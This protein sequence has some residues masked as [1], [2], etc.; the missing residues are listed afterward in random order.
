M[1]D[2]IPYQP[3]AAGPLETENV[4]VVVAMAGLSTHT[5]RAYKRWIRNYLSA[6]NQIPPKDIDLKSLNVDMAAQSFGPAPLKAWL[7]KLKA[8]KLGKQSIMQAKASV[9][10]LAQFMADLGRI[11]YSV[12]SGLSRVKAPRAETGQRSGTWLTQDEI[13]QLL[14]ALRRAESGNKALLTRNTAIIVLMVT[15][16]LRRDEV[17]AA[18]WSDLARQGRNNI[19]RVH[20]KGEKLRTVKVPDMAHQAIEAWRVYHPLP[21]GE[22]AVFTRIWKGGAVTTDGLT[23]R[24]VWMVVQQSAKRAGLP[25]ISPHDLRRS[26]ARGAYEAGVSF[27]LIRQ[28]LGHSNIATTERYVNS[29]LELDRAATDIWATMLDEGE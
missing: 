15:C 27:E 10:W 18:L 7:G 22:R 12:P 14:L 19:L 5:Q 25:R 29:V 24:A 20:G 3:S 11:D 26:F 2:L 4:S 21:E 9:V 6:V 16:G 1:T 13:R 8:G 17:A 23:D 28:A